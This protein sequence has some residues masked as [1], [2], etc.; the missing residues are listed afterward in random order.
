[1][2][3]NKLSKEEMAKRDAIIV[4]LA[5]KGETCLAIANK[6]N[7]TKQRSQ[8]ILDKYGVKPIQIK[9]SI[10]KAKTD[11]F[12]VGNV[13]PLLDAGYDLIDVRKKLNLSSTSI[14]TL[15]RNGLDMRLQTPE[16]RLAKA[17][18]CYDLYMQGYTARQIINMVDGLFYPEDVYRRVKEHAGKNRLPKR[19]SSRVKRSNKLDNEIKR[20]KAK[21][22][23]NKKITKILIDKGYKNLNGGDLTISVILWRIRKLKE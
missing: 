9:R 20:L 21:S 4:E 2:K 8:Q 13:K 23:S 14:E 19:L 3:K 17:K 15:K 7:I 22:Y 11:A 6:F 1:M 16:E 12:F 10:R 5:L 18:E